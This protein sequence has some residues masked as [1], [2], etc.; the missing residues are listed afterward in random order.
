MRTQ[1]PRAIG[2]RTVPGRQEKLLAAAAE[3]LIRL[4]LVALTPEVLDGA[5]AFADSDLR[6]LDAIHVA[7]ALLISAEVE[8]FLSYDRRQAAAARAAGL[9]VAEPG[10]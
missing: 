9:E 10:R 6:S 3:R 2:R 7:S 5:G 8:C 4:H 1:I